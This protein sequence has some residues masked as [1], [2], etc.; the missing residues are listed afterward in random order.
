[1]RR[2]EWVALSQALHAA[3]LPSL[4]EPCHGKVPNKPIGWDNY[5][6]P[7]APLLSHLAASVPNVSAVSK[8]TA[9]FEPAGP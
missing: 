7:K 2:H 3:L 6:F 4:L 8:A 9:G 5:L 1:M